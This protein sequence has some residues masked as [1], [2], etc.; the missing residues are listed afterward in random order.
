MKLISVFLFIVLLA[1]CGKAPKMKDYSGLQPKS[2]KSAESLM[3]KSQEEILRLKYNN[4]IQ[5]NCVLRVSDGG[6]INFSDDPTDTLIWDIPDELT[7]LR[8]MNFH[9]GKDPFVIVVR[10]AA[11]MKIMD[12]LSFTALD[13]RE[14]FMEHSPVLK[15]NYRRAPKSILTNG[16]VHDK[17]TFSVV[18]LYENVETRL[19]NRITETDDKLVSEDLRCTLK[20]RINLAYKDQW[21]LVK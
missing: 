21:K 14:Y 3:N 19:E 2:S 1:G 16:S 17:E 11:P 4:K 18:N 20:T 13:Q 9:L 8:I 15:I 12:Q 7:K 6:K 5:L 10:M